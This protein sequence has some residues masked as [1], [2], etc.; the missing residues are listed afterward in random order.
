M[1]SVEHPYGGQWAATPAAR[2]QTSKHLDA[3]VAQILCQYTADPTRMYV[4]GENE[5]AS[6]AYHWAAVSAQPPLGMVAVGG[7]VGLDT[8]AAWRTTTHRPH[9]WTSGVV[10][11]S[12]QTLLRQHSRSWQQHPS[13]ATLVEADPLIAQWM[14]QQETVV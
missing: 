12:I 6:M 1:V 4:V 14:G 3:T 11:P 13:S 5:G 7:D 9:L 2:V 8:Q 10:S